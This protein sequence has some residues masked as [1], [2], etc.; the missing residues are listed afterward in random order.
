M[1]T[2]CDLL[3]FVRGLL[4]GRHERRCMQ[5]LT[6]MHPDAKAGRFKVLASHS[7]VNTLTTSCNSLRLTFH[8]LKIF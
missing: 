8:F 4:M 2:I 3:G 6:Q 5:D 1:Y 7:A